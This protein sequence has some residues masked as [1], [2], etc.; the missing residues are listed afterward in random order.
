ML[1][2]AV[3]AEVTG[4]D[5]LGRGLGRA[6]HDADPLS[7]PEALAEHGDELP[8]GHGRLRVGDDGQAPRVLAVDRAGRHQGQD[9]RRARRLDVRLGRRR[10]HD[11]GVVAL[12]T[13]R[14]QDETADQGQGDDSHGDGDERPAARRVDD[15]EVDLDVVAVRLV[16]PVLSHPGPTLSAPVR[17]R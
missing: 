7:G 10:R 6:H 12:V 16:V 15:L 14:A 9:L 11:V 2:V 13:H 4:G 17:T 3:H 8:V 5:A 1:E